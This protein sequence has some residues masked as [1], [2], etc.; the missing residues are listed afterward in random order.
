MGGPWEQIYPASSSLSPPRPTVTGGAGPSGSP[1]LP[2]F[3]VSEP[4]RG[5]QPSHIPGGWAGAEHSKCY[6]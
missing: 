6:L 2:L 4:E 5:Q 1:F 3:P